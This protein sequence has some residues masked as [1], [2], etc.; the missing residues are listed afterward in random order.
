MSPL[1][2]DVE[3]EEVDEGPRFGAGWYSSSCFSK[4]LKEVAEESEIIEDDEEEDEDEE[5]MRAN[6][7]HN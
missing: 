3:V 4:Q 6:N 2:E 5:D 1:R 7:N